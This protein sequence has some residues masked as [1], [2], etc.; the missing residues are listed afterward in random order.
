MPNTKNPAPLPLRDFRIDDPFWSRYMDLVRDTV[1]PYQWEALNDRIPDAEPSFA[2]R[3]FRIAA[4]LEEGEYGGRVFQDSDV[5]KWL[6]AVGYSLAVRPDPALEATADAMI[7]LIGQAQHPDGYLNTYFTLKEPGRRWT[8]LCDCH[9]LYCAGHMIEAAVAYYEGTG[10]RKLL[11]ILCRYA[12]YIATVFGPGE[13]Q[14]RG[15]DG[16]EEI[17]LALV[18]LYGAT[19]ET[20]YLDLARFFVEERGQEPNFLL[21]EFRSGRHT[22]PFRPTHPLARGNLEY[23]QA[24]KPVTEQEDATGHAVRAMYLYSAMADLA[25]ETG[26]EGMLRACRRLWDSTVKRRMY[27]TGGIGSARDGEAFTLDWDL[28]NDTVYAESCASVGLSMFA[29]RMLRLDPDAR[30]ADVLE[31]ALYNTVLGAM[32]LDGKHFFYVNPLE[33]WPAASD[34]NPG[35]RHVKPE[36]QAWFGCACCPPNV[37]RLLASLGRY[38]ASAGGDTVRVHLYV[39]GQMDVRLDKGT[40]RLHIGGGYPWTEE[41]RIRVETSDV[42]SFRLALRI[43]GWCRRWSARLNGE[44]VSGSLDKGYLCIERDWRVGDE[45]ALSLAMPVEMLQAHP[46]VRADAGKVALQ[47]GPLVYCLE[48]ADNGANLSALSIPGDAVFRYTFDDDLPGGAGTIRFT[49]RRLREADWADTLY[50]PA[51]GCGDTDAAAIR[52][53]PYF[54]WGNRGRGEMT[55]WIRCDA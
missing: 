41:V 35:R 15:Y 17:E 33:V 45:V 21:E 9:E 8:N 38:A 47:R 11:D 32:A 7:E 4:G 5:A 36:R 27:V 22:D 14:L 34:R 25:R 19:G 1:I 49:G 16:H 48:E 20:K 23:F 10:K 13:G 42:P 52:A 26:D 44:P 50:R 2:I 29:H 28:P 24:H 12:D 55:V 3:N 43:P 46:Q 53:V 51:E 40:A 37:A 54:L 30:Y 39:G 6:E 18:R 31:R